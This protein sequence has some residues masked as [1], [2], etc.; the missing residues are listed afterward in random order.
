MIKLRKEDLKTKIIDVHTHSVGVAL[1]QLLIGNYPYAQDI[2][3]LS[4]KLTDNN[5]DF[6]ITFPMTYPIYFNIREMKYNKRYVASGNDEFPYCSENRALFKMIEDMRLTNLI[7][8]P[9][10]ST[11]S[12]IEKQI[13]LLFELDKKYGVQGL[14]YHPKIERKSVLSEE[15]EPFVNFAIEKNI[16]IM[17]HTDMSDEANP[18]NI[19]KLSND[20]AELRVCAAHCAHFDLKFWENLKYCP[21]VFVDTSPFLRV[22]YDTGKM[23]DKKEKIDTDYNHPVEVVK[24]LYSLAPKQ[25]MW[26]TDIPYNRFVDEDIVIQYHD[27]KKLLDESGLAL[28]MSENT[29]RFLL[30]EQS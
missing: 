6:A 8:F 27:D 21:N 25:I 2:C 11:N 23:D 17:V 9:A 14:K 18:I 12:E 28:E 13:E 15:F 1:G 5:V 16:P 4:E 10:V 19:I 7:P 22:C 30:G 24:R 26:G 29:I 3:D 20:Y